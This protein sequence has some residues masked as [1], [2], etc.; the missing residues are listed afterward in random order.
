VFAYAFATVLLA[1]LNIVVMYKIGIHRFD[2]IAPL[3]LC[4]V[5]EVVGISVH[6]GS[7]S[8]MIAVLIVGNGL[9][10]V[11]AAYK[12]TAPLQSREAVP[13][14]PSAASDAA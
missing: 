7:L 4:A 3:A 11:C 9:A 1:G 2:F 10:L 8:D 5:G 6:H 14:P 13:A 12:V